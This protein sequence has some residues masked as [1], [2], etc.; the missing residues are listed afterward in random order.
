[1]DDAVIIKEHVIK[2]SDIAKKLICRVRVI[3]AKKAAVRMKIA[4]IFFKIGASMAGMKS[5]VDVEV[6]DDE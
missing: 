5:K 1:M 2:Y 4:V 3:G 6:K